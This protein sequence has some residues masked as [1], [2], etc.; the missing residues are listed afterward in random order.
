[1]CGN[2]TGRPQRRSK[3]AVAR[4][5]TFCAR[6]VHEPKA[7]GILEG[8]ATEALVRGVARLAVLG[9]GSWVVGLLLGVW[10]VREHGFEGP[11]LLSFAPGH[12][13]HASDV[14]GVVIAGVLVRLIVS[15]SRAVGER[16][17]L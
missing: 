11:R 12:G 8:M 9:G 5:T 13:V 3:H 4:L 2:G 16:Q 14:I 1:M 7:S 10:V 15:L 6:G 17:R